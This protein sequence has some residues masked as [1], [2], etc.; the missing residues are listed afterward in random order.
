MPAKKQ[1]ARKKTTNQKKSKY[2]FKNILFEKKRKVAYVT[3]NRPEVRNAL[4]SETREE[5]AAAL[6]DAWL[7]DKIGVIVL[8]GAG[9]KA[10]SAGGDLSWIVDPKKKVD[11]RY[12]Q[13]HYRLA[14][15]MRNCGKPIIARVDGYC[16]GG[17]NELNM[18]CDLTI[19]S[20][21]SIFAQA[22]PLVGSAPIWYGI[23]QLQHSV[24]DKKTREI[25]YLCNRYTAKEA[26][27]MGWINKVVPKEDLDKEVSAWCTRLLEM[28]PQSLR[29]A[30]LQINYNSDMSHSQVSHGLELAR[31]FMKAPEMVEGASA[32]LEK[33]K[34]DFWKVK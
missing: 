2:N 18:L 4:N 19:A 10:F 1:S 34:P 25:V 33:R 29:I 16:I 8:T 24:G 5:L 21:N 6:E 20:E 11:A 26:M 7:D 14:T 13:V 12:M 23:Q 17:G 9:G 3:I 30:K 22:G 28:S 27:E 15:A 31:F 32:F